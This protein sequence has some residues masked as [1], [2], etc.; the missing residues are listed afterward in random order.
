[1]KHPRYL[2]GEVSVESVVYFPAILL[3][4]L[5]GFHLAALMHTTHIGSL[6]AT[7]GAHVAAGNFETFGNITMAVDE[8][9]NVTT[10]LGG[11]RH[12]QPTVSISER[13][14]TVSV[15]VQSPRIVP[16]LPTTVIRTA[17]SSRELFLQEQ[18]R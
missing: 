4:V 7:R 15:F 8:V 18:E 9:N 14:V 6:A 1:M 5:C 2:R 11:T 10:E 17:S 13:S 3:I 16:F 12:R